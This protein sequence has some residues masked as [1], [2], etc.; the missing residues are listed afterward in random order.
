[1]MKAKTKKNCSR[2]KMNNN[3]GWWIVIGKMKWN[4]INK[5]ILMKWEY[6]PCGHDLID[7]SQHVSRLTI[8]T[9]VM[10][11]TKWDPPFF[12]DA[13][14][15]PFTF[16]NNTY[17][18]IHTYSFEIWRCTLEFRF[19]LRLQTI[20]YTTLLTKSFNIHVYIRG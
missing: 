8:S 14:G 6:D 20:Y 1:M 9:C 19:F 13:Y 15:Y 17:N 3:N 18:N 12:F 4:E 2:N 16:L 11:M 10:T 7:Q 5:R